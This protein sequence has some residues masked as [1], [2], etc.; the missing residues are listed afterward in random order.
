MH[1]HLIQEEQENFRLLIQEEEEE[2]AHITTGSGVE[3]SEDVDTS[4]EVSRLGADRDKV[5]TWATFDDCGES[6]A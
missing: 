4:D 1:A 6:P 5:N 2:E 3:A